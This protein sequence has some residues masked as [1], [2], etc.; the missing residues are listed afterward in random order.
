MVDLLK[1]ADAN[2][3]QTN[4]LLKAEFVKRGWG[5]ELLSQKSSHIFIDRRDGGAKLHIFGST[6]PTTSFAAGLLANDKFGIYE[7]LKTLDVSQ[8]ETIAINSG[9]PDAD[10]AAGRFLEKHSEV[11]VK[12]LDGGHGNGIT[13]GIKNIEELTTAAQQAVQYNRGATRR[14]LLQQMVSSD[15]LDVRILCINYKYIAAINRVPASVTGDGTHTVGELIDIENRT[16]RGKAYHAKL[17]VVDRADAEK[18]LGAEINVIPKNGEKVRVLGVANYGRGGELIDV[19][20]DIPDWMR[21]EAEAISRVSGLAVCG[22]D[23][24]AEQLSVQSQKNQTQSYVIEINKTPS[25]A[26][27]D[28]PTIGKN[29]GAIKSY[30]DY[31]GDLEANCV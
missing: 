3:S 18:Y 17:A 1:I 29:R 22:V 20:D 12:P 26:I 5:A 30:V 7:L 23:Y 11:V 25:L 14:V 6:P 2:L 21:K 10:G 24:L 8:P 4:R 19:S 16:L 15:L 13:V 9:N 28:E 27:H 31:L